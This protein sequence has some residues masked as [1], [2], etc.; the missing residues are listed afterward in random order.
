MYFCRWMSRL[1][2]RSPHR[3]RT[4]K[5]FPSWPHRTS[6]RWWRASP[7]IS[8]LAYRS[9]VQRRLEWRLIMRDQ[10]FIS[11]KKPNQTKNSQ[12]TKKYKNNT[13]VDRKYLSIK[14][15]S[16]CG[17]AC[18]DYNEFLL[19]KFKNSESSGCL[20]WKV[21][22]IFNLHW[23]YKGSL[24]RFCLFWLICFVWILVSWLMPQFMNIYSPINVCYSWTWPPNS[25]RRKTTWSSV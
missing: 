6:W 5:P 14:K 22:F 4:L 8:C 12:K 20:R 18:M 24:F 25:G 2:P 9:V 15:Q 13:A 1:N 10:S 19:T 17:P 23:N 21:Q 11:G 7:R 16:P 3:W